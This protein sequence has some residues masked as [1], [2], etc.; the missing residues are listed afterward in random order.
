MNNPF[1]LTFGKEPASLI[2]R[3][4]QIN[5]IIDNFKEDN[6]SIQAFMITGVRGSGKTVMLTTVSNEFRK[7]KEW[8]VA[9]LSPERDILN[10][11]AADLSN[12]K[13]LMQMFR[14]A[15][16]NLSFLGLGL[17]IDG[18]PPVTDTVVALGQMLERLTKKGKRILV[19]I[20]EALSNKYVR[21]F[22]SQF[23]IFIRQNYNIFLLMTGL[24]ENI[25]ELQ[26][27][28]SLTFLYR[29]PK[30]QMEPLSISMIAYKYK[31]VFGINDDEAMNMA[32]ITK[33]Y[34][35]AYQTLGYL[36]CKRQV[37]YRGVISEFDATMA[38]Y[39]YEKIW[40]ELSEGDRNVLR[41][42]SCS[43]KSAV[44]DIRAEIEM[45]SNT[46]AVYRNRLLKKGLIKSPSYGN[47]ELT[48]PRFDEFIRKN[49]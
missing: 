26:N 20:D 25:Y 18:I 8:I 44:K 13:E 27:E 43:E 9:D 46:F 34:P 24:Y 21:E 4:L 17:E 49:A 36:C 6:P 10:A 30:I 33:G 35:F 39:V 31:E 3:D 40:S 45:D 29:A 23:Q 48:L 37:A 28:K 7:D 41:A 12:R 47:V 11:L 5:E 38:M 1:S 15:K 19:T 16:I 32:K 14:D 42:I 22:V 2:T